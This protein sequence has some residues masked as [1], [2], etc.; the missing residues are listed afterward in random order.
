MAKLIM[1]SPNKGQLSDFNR[2]V[3]CYIEQYPGGYYDDFLSEESEFQVWY[4]L[5]E[6][7]TGLLS[8]YPFEKNACVLEIGAGFGALTG[9]LCEKCG[10]VM[11]TERSL[12]RAEALAK[13]WADKD[14]LTV[15]GGEWSEI[16]FGVKFDYIILTGVLER[17]AGGSNEKEK[18]A[19]YLKKASALLKEGGKLLF[20][21][22]NRFGLRYFCGAAEPHT[23]RAFDGINRFRKGTRG[24]SFSKKELEEIVAEAEFPF[25]KFYYPLPDY[26]LPQMIYTDAYLPR[27][28]LKERLLPYYLRNDTLIASEQ[29]LYDDVIDNGVFPFF[30]NSFLV[31]CGKEDNLCSVAYAAVSTDRGAER[32]YATVINSGREIDS[33]KATTG[34]VINYDNVVKKM[35]LHSAGKENARK[36]YDN[37][38]DL[39]RR[40]IPVVPHK[41]LEDGSLELPYMDYPT[42]SDYIKEIMGKDEELF[43]RLIDKIYEYILQSSEEVSREKNELLLQMEGS[44][45]AGEAEQVEA[46]Q[47][48]GGQPAGGRADGE[49]QESRSKAQMPDFGPI[50]EKAYIELIPLNCFINLETG[51]FFY[52]DQ[53]FVYNNYPAKYVLF[54]AIHYIYCFTPNAQR[55]YPRQKL[56][57]RYGMQDT[58]DIYMREELRFLDKVRNHKKYKKFYEW[59]RIDWKRIDDNAGRLESEAE[60][61]ANYQISDKMKKT[62]KIELE[63]LDEIDRICKKYD[64]QYFLIHGSLLGAVR[65]KGFIPWDDDLDVAM[66]R[67]DYDRFLSLA[68]QELAEP[69]SLH[70][71]ATEKDIFWGG[72]ARMRNGQTTGIET[73]ELNH[74]G[75]LGIWVD[76][77]PLDVCTMDDDKFLK[78]QKKIRRCHRLINAKIYGR[79]YPKRYGDMKPLLWNTFRVL[80]HFYSQEK[81]AFMLDNAMKLYTDEESED[82]AFFNGYFRHRR[83]SA[84]DFQETVLLDFERRKIPAP[85]GYENYLFTI[86]GKDYMKYPPEEERKPHHRGIFDPEKP[87]GEY[88]R[89]F[90]E[91]FEGAKGKKIILFGSGLMFEN[92]MERYGGKYRPAF[93]VDNDENKWGRSRMGIGIKEPKA[94]LE[95]PEKKRHLIICSFYYR[96]ISQ[97]LDKMGIRD[98][99]VYIQHMDW[100]LKTEEQR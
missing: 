27:K 96:E 86:M 2:Q 41:L 31:E 95:V 92:Y 67:K 36:L 25:S 44:E 35:P 53:E 65:H 10:Q 70:T 87:Y 26:K 59:T 78:K 61:I 32:S 21:V 16:D 98:Y 75:N 60:K 50:L 94:I 9:L 76:I 56:I 58:W 80:S 81:L 19:A 17:I 73:R 68:A 34:T 15:Y 37:I 82:V 97:Q 29:E 89:M 13:R 79:D 52:F 51:E 20:A 83:L 42:L 100:I 74:K 39:K 38:E 40:K 4:Q 22:E 63:M 6:L 45:E 48:A 90:G 66:P 28:N 3:I 33:S 72:F 47:T 7:R 77:L 14:N 24:Y 62:W 57:E 12:P 46:N 11:A 43:L 64:F 1:N 23:N 84:K 93:L 91:T 5:S 49:Q 85:I 54:R 99:K 71:A 18:Y 55:Y 8:W 69:L 88:Q 30:A